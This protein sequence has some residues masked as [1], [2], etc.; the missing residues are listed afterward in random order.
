MKSI[1]IFIALLSLSLVS[2][3][4]TPEQPGEEKTEQGNQIVISK[5]QFE[6]SELETGNLRES[7]F[8]EIV[9]SN[10]R[11]D[12][13][14]QNRTSI[15]AFL[16]GYIRNIELLEGDRVSKGQFLVSLESTE[17]VQLQQDYMDVAGQLDYLKAEFERQQI[18]LKENIT[19]RKS[20]L[21]AESDYNRAQ[22]AAKSLQS[23]LRMLNIDP[24]AVEEGKIRSVVNIYSPIKGNASNISVS[25]GSFVSP[26]DQIMEIINSEHIHLELVVFEKDVR[27]IKEGQ[28]IIFNTPEASNESFEAEVVLVGKTIDEQKRNV[29]VHGHLPDSIASNFTVGMFVEALILTS[30]VKKSGLPEEAVVEQDGNYFVLV[31]E[32]EDEENYYFNKKSVSPGDTFNGV[33]SLENP[34]SLENQTIL[35]KG[36]FKL[37]GE[38]GGE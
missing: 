22:A 38:A 12:V 36:A 26:T 13:P 19:S 8:P 2:C 33:T 28:K 29:R 10:G 4:E 15:N 11:I 34:E 9:R 37:I 31:L 14:P 7:D 6:D 5:A 18:M 24:A 35:L 32:K 16:G 1:Y 23:K 27:K 17:Y 3:K 21:K 25:R 20:F 30:E